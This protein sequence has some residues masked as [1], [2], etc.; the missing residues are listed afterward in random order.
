MKITHKNSPRPYFSIFFPQLFGE[1]P[2]K[3]RGGSEATGAAL[4]DAGP[5]EARTQGVGIAALFRRLRTQNRAVSGAASVAAVVAGTL[6]LA[7]PALANDPIY[8]FATLPSNTEAGAHPNV[9]FSFDI[10]N[11][12]DGSLDPC[13]CGDAKEI[14]VHLPTGLIGNTHATPQ[15]DV[16]HFSAD[17]CPSD[18]QVGVSENLLNGRPGELGLG[19]VS[20]LSAVFN[21]VP[22]PDEPALF[23]FKTPLADTPIFIV[24][25]ARTNSDYGVDAAVSNI[26]HFDPFSTSKTVFWGVPAS[27]IHNVLRF[28]FGEDVTEDLGGRQLLCQSDGAPSTDDP[29][30][31][32]S[33]CPIFNYPYVG[34]EGPVPSES[35]EIPFFQN[36]TTCGETSLSTSLG[37]LSYDEGFTEALS[38]Y[39]ATTECSKLTFNPSQSIS[40]TT[41]AA[42]SPSG[43]EFR[44]TVPQFES[45][46]VPSPSELR[47]AEVTLPE[48]FSLAPNV[49]NGKDT[50]SDAQARFGTTEE[51]QCPED[52]KIGTISVS[53]PVLPGLL[54]GAVYLGEPKPGNRFRMILA[55]N[56]FGIHVKLPGSV[57]PDPTTGQIHIDFQNLPQAPFA[58][59]NMH[60]FGSERGPLDTPTQCGTYEV[61]SVFTPWDSVLAPQ[62]SRQFFNVDE[63][64]L[65]Q[66]P[67]PLPPRPHRRRHRCHRCRPHLLLPQPHPR[68]R[69]TEPQ[70]PQPHHPTRLRRHP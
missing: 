57:T 45:P 49:T 17:Q 34:L 67:P 39:P 58:E 11:R 18:S 64:C 24:I 35:P 26:N 55:F 9:A 3:R 70:R 8:S 47:A 51:A 33:L 52:S 20:F 30:T 25:S 21:L 32:Q 62:T 29:A 40:P 10:G 5:S 1:T 46:A 50:C 60:I 13:G 66:R 31:L 63:N 37:V 36:P 7:S 68:R 43:A 4:G 2:R 41:E 69:R 44:L 54:P 6:L 14:T 19:D 53:T 48:G 12:Q 22:P 28:S 65:R 61:Q 56:G 27:P 59:F 38:P 23:A 16:A 42:D 15:C